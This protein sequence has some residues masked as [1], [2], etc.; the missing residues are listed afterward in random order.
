M[1]IPP[2]PDFSRLIAVLNRSGTTLSNN[3]LYQA[4]KQL[5]DYTNQ[6]QENLDGRVGQI[7]TIISGGGGGGGGL[8]N[9]TYLTSTDEVVNLPNSRELIAGTNFE[10]NDSVAN[11]RTVNQQVHPFILLGT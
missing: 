11:E 5:I 3:P 1:A 4:V 9:L 2:L 7:V 10:F 8:S 6:S